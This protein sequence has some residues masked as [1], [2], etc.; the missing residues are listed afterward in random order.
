MAVFDAN[1]AECLVFTFKEGLLSPVAH[2]LKL[3][4]AQLRLEVDDATRQVRLTVDAA[5]IRVI[6]AMKEGVEDPGA[7]GDKDRAKIEENL[8][9]SV[10]EVRRFPE[11]RFESTEVVP[12]GEGFRVKGALSLHGVRGE[13]SFPVRR[14]ETGGAS[15][16]V[17]EVS[18]HQPDFGI[19]PFSAMMGALKVKPDV[20]VR[21]SAPA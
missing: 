9:D 7:L 20:T 18:L 14:I 12:E 15:R 3:K 17:G 10:L 4:A 1:V 5:S 2:N 21:V 8:R 11:I 13:L 6:N 19:K 16:W